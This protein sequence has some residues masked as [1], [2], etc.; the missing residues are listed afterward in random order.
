MAMQK[1]PFE[2]MQFAF[3]VRVCVCPLLAERLSIE[4]L[5]AAPAITKPLLIHPFTHVTRQTYTS[6]SRSP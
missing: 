2:D 4:L 3:L 1:E 6:R 5:K